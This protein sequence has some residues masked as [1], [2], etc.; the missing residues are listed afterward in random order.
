MT[1]EEA[2]KA[3]SAKH[4]AVIDL[5]AATGLEAKTALADA[6]EQVYGCKRR[7]A[8]NAASRMVRKCA[9]RTAFVWRQSQVAEPA[10]AETTEMLARASV[11]LE[12][13]L[14]CVDAV[15]SAPVGLK[16]AVDDTTGAILT[17]PPSQ[18]HRWVETA[19]KYLASPLAPGQGREGEVRR[20]KLLPA[21]LS[22]EDADELFA[23]ARE[24]GALPGLIRPEDDDERVVVIEQEPQDDEV[25]VIQHPALIAAGG[26][27]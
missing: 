1:G 11:T 25:P 18:K 17:V 23:K 15:I 2:Y 16:L 12:K 13:V 27:G 20:E 7:S 22:R 9:F 14:R 26:G 4:R 5:A 6:W 24:A 10:L 3:L 8:E 19:F 21:S